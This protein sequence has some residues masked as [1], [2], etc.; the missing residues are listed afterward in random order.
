MSTEPHQDPI[1]PNDSEDVLPV[2]GGRLILGKDGHAVVYADDGSVLTFNEDDEN[3]TMEITNPVVSRIE[4]QDIRLVSSYLIGRSFDD[5]IH[6][7]EFVGGGRFS[8]SMNP[9][10]KVIALTLR[11]VDFFRSPD[12]AVCL[13]GTRPDF[14]PNATT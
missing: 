5:T 1:K 6:A 10:G 4:I 7:I 14:R 3:G 11:G 2:E 13:R 9:A 8:Y 12:D